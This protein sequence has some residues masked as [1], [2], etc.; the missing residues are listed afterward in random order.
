MFCYQCEETIGPCNK[1]GVCGKDENVAGVQ[2]A[3]VYAVK[4]VA[5]DGQD[6]KE[7]NSFIVESLFVTITN[8]NF[9]K[10][11]IERRIEKANEFV[12]IT[13]EE[14]EENKGV[15][16]EEDDDKRS[17]KETLTYGLKGMAAYLYHAQVLGYNDSGI[18]EFIRKAL[19]K[20]L[21]KSSADELRDLV[22]KAGSF[23]VKTME[24][25]DTAHTS[26][27]GHPQPTNVSTGVGTRP[28]ILVSGH[29][30]RDLK[31]LLEQT[32]DEEIDVYTN[33]EMLPAHYYP[34][35]KKYQHLY[36]NY[37]GSWPHQTKDFETFNGPVLLTTNCLVPPKESYRDRVYTTGPVSFRG[38]EHIPEREEGEQKDFSKIIG[39]AK[40]TPLPQELENVTIKGGYAHG[41]VLSVADKVVDAVNN[42]AIKKFV[43]MAGC[44]GRRK[45]R[46]YYTE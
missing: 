15:E 40:Q 23:G 8:V 45:E 30:L 26:T 11:D 9:N 25:L 35:L 43:V 37:G 1:A 17:L 24:L 12:S 22:L 4:R 46:K 44:D 19:S 5:K 18:E 7:E 2:D 3:L 38:C 42:G 28:G 39:H 41:T 20:T 36:G 10:E 14:I 27:Y 6:T 29:D 32:K 21:E 13:N 16:K 33:G 31:E 34:E